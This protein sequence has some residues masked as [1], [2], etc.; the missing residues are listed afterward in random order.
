MTSTD[1]VQNE[2]EAQRLAYSSPQLYHTHTQPCPMNKITIHYP[3][4]LSCD[5]PL[6][7]V[8]P[9]SA[10]K[11]PVYPSLIT[12]LRSDGHWQAGSHIQYH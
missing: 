2:R 6:P 10:V 4:A 5:A 12:N 9:L 11:Y 7:S 3:C 1:L 8:Q